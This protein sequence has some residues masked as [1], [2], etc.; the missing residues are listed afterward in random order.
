VILSYLAPKFMSTR[1]V[2]VAI[3]G[4]VVA[5]F[6]AS[7]SLFDTRETFADEPV[8]L[9]SALPA[10]VL[11]DASSLYLREAASGPVRWQPWSDATFT[12]A[13]K[14]NRPLLIDIGAVWCHWCHV[15][16]QTTY[17]DEK[18]AAVINSYFV[19]VKVDT[20]ERPDIDGYYQMAAR[21]FSA[22]G[23]PLTCFAT[24]DGA[25]LL[26]AG[27][28]PPDASER[29]G[30]LWVLERVKDA[31]AKDPNFTKLA[32]EV[33]AKVGTEDLGRGKSSSSDELRMA[34]LGGTKAAFDEQARGQAAGAS[35]YDFPATRMI[36]AHGFFGHPEFTAVAVARLKAIAAGGVFDQLGGGLHRYST[37]AKWRVPHFEKMAYDQAMALKT[38]AET[39]ET[40]HDED[41][42]RV[43]KAIVKYVNASMLDPKS[44]AFYSHQD[45]DSFSGD[46]GSYYSWTEDEVRRVLNGRDLEVALLHFGFTD[47][48]ARAPDGRIVMR[49]A[50]GADDIANKLRLTHDQ[51]RQSVES[52]TIKMTAARTKRRA[53]QV[54]TTILIDRNALMAS[55]YISAAEALGDESL[56][57]IGL[58][59]LDY[60]DANARSPDGSFYHVL[61][62]GKPAVPGLAADQV[63]MMG[64]E[65]DAYQASGDRKYLDRASSLDALIFGSYRDSTT[66]LLKSRAPV[67]AGTVVTQAASG[68]QVFY[69]DP[70]PA[71]Q[72]AAAENFQT[73]AA[74]TS[75]PRYATEAEQLIRPASSR[76]GAFAGPNNGALGL[77]LE[78]RA[79]GEAVVAIAGV[80]KNSQSATALMRVALATYRPG[81]VVIRLGTM[82]GGASAPIPEAMKAMY[83]ASAHRDAPLAFVCAGTACARPSASADAL[84]KTIRDFGVN[85]ASSGNLAIR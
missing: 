56:A 54:D 29:Q 68:A 77:A 76:I 57:R 73:L 66:G 55:A 84:A 69:D 22:G 83:E 71:I 51:A 2:T 27:Y 67:T 6:C 18:V 11:K 17:A 9:Q 39:Y 60:L 80:D 61:D 64:A 26:I 47:D 16:D 10:N 5:I 52:A 48:P 70:T 35:F 59:D 49:D 74:L 36:L 30:M 20:D 40:N 79:D 24:P 7:L 63:Y 23:W 53:P 12:L 58:E 32:H 37:D 85:R 3:F 45:A 15:M 33:A 31:Y 8:P 81:K 25:P 28:L 43:A 75:D 78:E 46:D 65:L 14:I 4:L 41:F 72:A 50:M 38:Y 34:I 1:N 13:R 21:N 44:H 42:A 82:E 62:R 19:P